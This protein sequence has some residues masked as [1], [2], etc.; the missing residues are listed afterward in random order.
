MG[1]IERPWWCQDPSCMPVHNN[2]QAKN[3]PGFGG[4]CCGQIPERRVEVIHGAVHD[5]DGHFCI[6]SPRSGVTMLNVQASDWIALGDLS[7][8]A[9]AK[10]GQAKWLPRL[11]RKC[12]AL[13]PDSETEP[14]D[15]R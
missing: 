15:E 11:A 9:L 13:S 5:N 6:R 8:I 3:E 10:W 4:F 1:E 7:I 2:A 12:R 14:E